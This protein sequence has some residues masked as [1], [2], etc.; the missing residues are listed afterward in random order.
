MACGQ[1]HA[2]GMPTCVFLRVNEDGTINVIAG[3]TD[4]GQGAETVICQMAAEEM[5]VPVEH[6]SLITAD[7][8]V[9][10]YDSL[11]IGDRT[12]LSAG[13]AVRRAAADAK[14]QI[15]ERVAQMFH[16]ET[17][18]L[19]L[20]NSKVFVKARPEQ[21]IPLIGV[22]MQAHFANRQGPIMGKGMFFFEERPHKEGTVTGALEVSQNVPNYTT[23]VAEVEVDERTGQVEVLKIIASEDVG[24]AINPQGVRGQMVGGIAMGVG[25]ALTEGYK[26]R[27]GNVLNRSLLD[28][29]IPGSLDVPEIETLIMEENSEQGPYGAKSMGNTPI[30]PTAPAIANAVYDAIGVRIT[31]LPITPDKVLSAL[32][33]KREK[34]E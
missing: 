19:D 1:F 32:R 12:T 4:N 27:D 8:G 16:C 22:S 31:D 33:K 17:D 29:G 21:A 23:Q 9:S 13:N 34:R 10:P 24:F 20:K 11:T 6:V 28:N 7:T 25:W 30:L 3:F 26:L 15:L 2:V 14:R 5:G 18:D